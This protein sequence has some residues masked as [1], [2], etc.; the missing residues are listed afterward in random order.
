MADGT[1][2]VAPLRQG[3]FMAQKA[4]GVK[5]DFCTKPVI[6]CKVVLY[7]RPSFGKPG[8]ATLDQPIRQLGKGPVVVSRS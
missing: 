5:R 4:A 8:G 2:A 3:L 1:L 6:W 7:S